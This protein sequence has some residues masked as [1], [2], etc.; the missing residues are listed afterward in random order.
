MSPHM[1]NVAFSQL[2]LEHHYQSFDI[3]PNQLADGI[4]ALRTLNV[5][6]FNVTIPHKVNV[7][8]YLDEIDEESRL[9]GAVNT[10]VNIDGR[11][12]GYNTDGRGYLSSLEQVIIKPLQLSNVL[13]VGAGG[14]ARAIVISMVLL[15]VQEIHIANRTLENALN[16]KKNCEQFSTIVKVSSIEDVSNNLSK[17]DIVINTTSIGMSPHVENAPFLINEIKQ[18]AVFSDLIYNPLKTK[19]LKE[20]EQ[21]GAIIHNGL[22]MF[23]HQGALAFE[24]WTGLKPS[25]EKMTE[26]VIKQLGGKK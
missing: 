16:I 24:M 8:Q 14:A 10:V 15:G 5:S 4:K 22:G 17:Y 3:E 9:I 13:V 1:H 20:A 21:K 12:I 19:W 11:L 18:G 23:V 2:G 26:V 6:G 25:L 7:I